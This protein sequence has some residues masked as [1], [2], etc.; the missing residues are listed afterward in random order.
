MLVNSASRQS[1]GSFTK[2]YLIDAKQADKL[3]KPIHWTESAI[4]Y[5][6]YEYPYFHL[7]GMKVTDATVVDMDLTGVG[8]PQDDPVLA[9]GKTLENSKVSS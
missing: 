9:W 6:P 5:N 1:C 4:T 2:G 7:D 8:F 3:I